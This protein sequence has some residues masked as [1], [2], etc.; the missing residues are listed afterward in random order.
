MATKADD[1]AATATDE[2]KEEAGSKTDEKKEEQQA[3]DDDG[4]EEEKGE[5]KKESKQ[6]ELPGV[7]VDPTKDPRVIEF[8]KQQRKEAAEEARRKAREENEKA[9]KKEKDDADRAK[10]EETD[11]LKLE[12]KEAEEKTVAAEKLAAFERTRLEI[13]DVVLNDKVQLEEGAI[14]FLEQKVAEALV[15]D[16]DLTIELAV[17]AVLSKNK[18]LVAKNE[19]DAAK[20]KTKPATTEPASGGETRTAATPK[21]QEG[22]DVKKLSRQEF[23]EH[24]ATKYG[25]TTRT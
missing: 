20:P 25:A 5:E 1:K 15:K 21:K 11:R 10:L 23:K 17:R 24:L 14:E 4:G 3:A 19:V 9:K 16:S 7:A 18:Y 22:V 2:K 6:P 13:R 8:V 12:K